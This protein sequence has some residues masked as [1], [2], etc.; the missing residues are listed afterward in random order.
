MPDPAYTEFSGS[1]FNRRVHF[2]G[3]LIMAEA[4]V[5]CHNTA[6]D[7]PKLDW[8]VGDVRGVQTVELEQPLAVSLFSFTYL[9]AYFVGAGLFGIAVSLLF[10]HRARDYR[11]LNAELEQANTFLARLSDSIG[12]YLPE[13][14]YRRIFQGERQAIIS[15]ERRMLTIFVSDLKEFTDTAEQLPPDALT[16]LLNE[17]FTEMSEIAARHG[18]TI[19]KFVGDAIIGFFGDPETLGVREDAVACVRMAL[20]MQGRMA[21]LNARWL[22][23]DLPQPLA[24]RIG[25]HTGFCSVGNFGSADRMNYTII[26]AA[27][28]LA[29]RL[30]HVAEPGGVVVSPE[31]FELVASAVRARRMA[32]I[33][34]KG[35][36][37]EIVPHIVEGMVDN[38]ADLDAADPD[39]SKAR[40]R[41]A[42]VRHLAGYEHPIA[43]RAGTRNVSR[44]VHEPRALGSRCMSSSIRFA[45]SRAPGSASTCRCLPRSTRRRRDLR[46]VGSFIV[47]GLLD[48]ET[49]RLPRDEFVQGLGLTFVTISATLALS[50]TGFSLVTGELAVLSVVGLLPVFAGIWLGPGIRHRIPEAFYR[51]LFFLSLIASGAYMIAQRSGAF[52]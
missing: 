52:G 25:I 29:A 32:P 7:S 24:A 49:L 13:Q 48:L 44:R 23:H 36:L 9:L 35:F 46:M 51:K 19:D 30:E 17:Y 40:E 34:L 10:W 43:R 12:R 6:P 4:C 42:K 21:E 33:R 16:R 47:P 26:G 11:R 45:L 18:A 8:K 15:A 22:Q 31:T 28:N 1:L 27:A 38:L 50:M 37:A 5:Q 39:V 14:I 3:P 2:A 41:D 20:A